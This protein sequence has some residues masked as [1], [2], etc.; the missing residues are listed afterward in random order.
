MSNLYT[1]DI[2]YLFLEDITEEI[3]LEI[4]LNPKKFISTFFLRTDIAVLSLV[5]NEENVNDDYIFGIPYTNFPA[6]KLLAIAIK[7]DRAD[8]FDFLLDCGANP[9]LLSV[10]IVN[11]PISGIVVLHMTMLNLAC[12]NKSNYFLIKLLD[13]GIDP[14]FIP[15]AHFTRLHYMYA[16]HLSPCHP[17]CEAFKYQNF[18]HV[19]V[20][21]AY[22]A[23]INFDNGNMTA[24]PLFGLLYGC[25][26]LYGPR[27]PFFSKRAARKAVEIMENIL[28]KG[29]SLANLKHPYLAYV[30]HAEMDKDYTNSVVELLLEYSID[31]NLSIYVSNDYFL[32]PTTLLEFFNPEGY[33][34]MYDVLPIKYLYEISP[35]ELTIELDYMLSFV[36]LLL[37]GSIQDFDETYNDKFV[38][39][40]IDRNYWNVLLYYLNFNN[41]TKSAGEQIIFIEYIIIEIANNMELENDDKIVILEELYK[42]LYR[43][44]K[45]IDK[46][47][48]EKIKSS[49]I[50]STIDNM[51]PDSQ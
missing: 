13:M 30:I 10:D 29:L 6:E 4:T 16:P 34:N 17:L 38:K 51:F 25:S 50:R 5:I 48:L 28:N 15:K 3:R 36:Y 43:Y 31:P 21:M 41:S 45:F 9:N 26:K 40:I 42:I 49:H 24:T 8:L 46:N 19:D 22:G 27:Q 39:I 18:S 14:N 20:L 12:R 35:I 47:F 33:G 7:N 11:D 37:A 32:S 2:N 44:G 1:D 23:D